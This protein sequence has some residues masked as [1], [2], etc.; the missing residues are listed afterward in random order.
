VPL[1][2]K[3][4]AGGYRLTAWLPAAAL[5][6]YDPEQS[7]RLGG[8]WVVRDGERGEQASGPTTD[9]PYAE[10]PTLWGV[11]DVVKGAGPG[12]GTGAPPPLASLRGR[13]LVGAD[14]ERT[15]VGDAT[16]TEV[17]G[18][19]RDGDDV[20]G[21]DTDEVLADLARDVGNDLVA[22]VEFD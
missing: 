6:G 11:L 22:A 2:V 21:Q 16:L 14:A 8:F 18:R 7:P 12:R 17:V 9:L 15:A 10:D 5:A 13:L 4:R 19:D 1:R 3:H 20:A